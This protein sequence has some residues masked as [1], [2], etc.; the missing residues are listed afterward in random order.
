MKGTGGETSF[1]VSCAISV[2]M[3]LSE[4]S[5]APRICEVLSAYR[6]IWCFLNLTPGGLAEA[7]PDSE[8]LGQGAEFTF[9][10]NSLE[11]PRRCW[12][13][14]CSE[15]ICPKRPTRQVTLP[16]FHSEET[17]GELGTWPHS[18]LRPRLGEVSAVHLSG[19]RKCPGKPET[20]VLAGDWWAVACVMGS[21]GQTR[22]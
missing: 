6:L 16:P 9:L 5:S 3:V 22:G 2:V 11:R 1:P 14:L 21:E 12:S 8:G 15:S 18:S 10:T 4:H 19:S 13:S 7:P 17:A 20:G